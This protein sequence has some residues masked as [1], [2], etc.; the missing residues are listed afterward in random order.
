MNYPAQERE[1]V[2]AGVLSS[3]DATIAQDRAVVVYGK[4][5][6]VQCDRTKAWLI[7]NGVQFSETDVSSDPAAMRFVTEVLGYQAVPVVVVEDPDAG[8][9]Q[10]SG[11]HWYGYRPDRLA[12]VLPSI[13][14]RP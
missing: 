5:S 11:V 1:D 14:V 3:L 8:P 2:L 12:A 6:C 10:E 13:G 7:R 9:N 4:P